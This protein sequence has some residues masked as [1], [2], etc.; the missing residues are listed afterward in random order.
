M[1]L[2]VL[3]ARSNI[4]HTL[5]P[6]QWPKGSKPQDLLGICRPLVMEACVRSLIQAL[7]LSNPLPATF[8]NEYPTGYTKPTISSPLC[9]KRS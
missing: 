9:E 5:A 1:D 8:Q 3:A 4:Q 2:V 7:Y 6:E